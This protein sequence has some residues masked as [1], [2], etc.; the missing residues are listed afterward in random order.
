MLPALLYEMLPLTYISAGALMI[1]TG[2]ELL[3]LLSAFLFY[4]AGSIIWVMRTENRRTD[5]RIAPA[6]KQLFLPEWMYEL[7]PFV[8]MF[9]GVVL[10]RFQFHT[11]WVVLGLLLISWGI[12]CVYRRSR[13][14][15]HKL[16]K[17]NSHIVKF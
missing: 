13:H 17:I 1:S 3:V 9:L 2:Q 7:K 16:K 15:H 11:V 14:R 4:C 10:I 6:H 5:H 12:I 8:Y